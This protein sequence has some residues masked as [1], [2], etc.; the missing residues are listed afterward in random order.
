VISKLKNAFTRRKQNI[1]GA[2][3][4]LIGAVAGA[5]GVDL[6]PTEIDVIISFIALVLSL[7]GRLAAEE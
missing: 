5:F 7:R 4:L 6:A 1:L 2:L 3:A